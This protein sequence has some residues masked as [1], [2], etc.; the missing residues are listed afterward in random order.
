MIL[1][2][3]EPLDHNI[4]WYTRSVT[5]VYIRWC[6]EDPE[7]LEVGAHGEHLVKCHPN[8]LLAK[9]GKDPALMKK[10][11]EGWRR[12]REDQNSFERWKRRGFRA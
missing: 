11:K 4:L 6:M 3:V 12:A 8:S 2:H 10:I 9:A 7:E 1:R 5:G